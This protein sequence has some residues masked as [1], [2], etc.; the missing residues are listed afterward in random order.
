MK[1]IV[2]SLNF[3]LFYMINA[4]AH[5]PH[6][7]LNFAYLLAE[8]LAY[9]VPFCL[10]FVWLWGQNRKWVINCTIALIFAFTISKIIGLLF[11]MMRPFAIPVGYK[12]L[13]HAA[14]LSFP[15]DHGTGIFTFAISVFLWGRFRSGIMALI[16]A[17]SMAWSRIY[18]GVHWPFDMLGGILVAIIAN[19]MTEFIWCYF[20]KSILQQVTRFYHFLFTGFIRR[21][22]INN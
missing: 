11:P 13:E 5:S 18:L 20:G 9:I 6:W 8:P 10:A 17:I 2:N 19:I 1:D 4:D 16:I 3:K 15:S 12:F 7:L 22:W 21:G 14:N